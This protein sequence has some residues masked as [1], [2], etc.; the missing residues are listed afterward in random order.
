[1]SNRMEQGT[2]P[3]TEYDAA[4]NVLVAVFETELAC[5][6]N[7]LPHASTF[8]QIKSEWDYNYIRHFE[9]DPPPPHTHTLAEMPLC[10][11]T[12]IKR[13]LYQLLLLLTR[14]GLV[15]T[16]SSDC[17]S[18]RAHQVIQHVWPP[19]PGRFIAYRSEFMSRL[20]F[21]TTCSSVLCAYHSSSSPLPGQI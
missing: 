5:G 10:L 13:L 6:S 18:L 4:T 2:L 11:S 8:R 3:A 12:T 9:S 20:S 1:V 16:S 21:I 15:V 14:R 19:P 7:L 17:T